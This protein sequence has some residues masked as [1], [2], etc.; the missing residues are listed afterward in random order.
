MRRGLIFIVLTILMLPACSNRKLQQSWLAEVTQVN[1]SRPVFTLE[2]VQDEI[3]A[4]YPTVKHLSTSCLAALLAK[5]DNIMLLDVREYQEYAVSHL[6]GAIQI[7]PLSASNQPGFRPSASAVRNK[8]VIFYCS[9][10]LRSSRMASE[11]Q[12]ELKRSGALNVYNL[13]GGL[14]A[15]HNQNRVMANR[16]GRTEFVHPFDEKHK[17]LLCRQAL[18]RFEP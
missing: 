1:G 2:K 18:A 16:N 14:F 10:G 7:E 5:Q 6:P 3:R 17:H 8:I 12:G 13:D 4:R 9:V 15:W 11:V